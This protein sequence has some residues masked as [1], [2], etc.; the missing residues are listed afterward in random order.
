MIRQKNRAD[1]MIRS[2]TSGVRAMSGALACLAFVAATFG[3]AVPAE[4]SSDVAG[5]QE[6]L[7]FLKGKASEFSLYRESAPEPLEFKEEPVLR[8]SIPERDNGTWDG[9]VFL[10]LERSRPVAAMSLGIRKPN[11][12]V[13]REQTSFSR[14]S[15]VCRR[16]GNVVWAPQTGGLLDR[17]LADAPP[18]ADT[19]V[20]RLTQMR[21]LARRFSATC[22]RRGDATQLR[23]LS[24]PLYRYSAD[25]QGILDGALFALVVSNDAE[26]LLLLE[27]ASDAATGKPKWRYSLARMSSLEHTVRLDDMEIWSIPR[28]YEIPAAERKTGPYVEVPMGFFNPGTGP[29]SK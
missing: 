27:A 16:S 11:N 26:M 1:G 3:Q 20:G 5:R 23:L 18:P 22:V 13:V 17:P 10:W 14:S 28:Y 8:Y 15:L 6:R 9:A 29:S 2:F 21:E 4:P 25:K 12:G 19:L 24:Q 7:L